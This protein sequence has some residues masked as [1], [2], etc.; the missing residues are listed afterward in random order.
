MSAYRTNMVPYST[1]SELANVYRAAVDGMRASLLECGK[2]LDALIEGFKQ[3]GRHS[4]YFGFG[5]SHMQSKYSLDEK[6][7][8]LL[9]REMKRH[10]WAV[11]VE[12]IEI[13]KVMSAK[14]QEE[15]RQA[16]YYSS[17]R[18]Y[19]RNE[20][21][22]I[23]AFPEITPESIIDVLMGMVSSAPE[24]LEE[25]IRE[26]FEWL[27]CNPGW[28]KL[29]TNE[30]NEF[31]VDRKVI[32]YGCVEKCCWDGQYWRTSYGREANLVALDYIFHGLDG[33]GVPEGHSGPLVTAIKTC[34]RD[35]YGTTEYFKFRCCKNSNLHIEFRR[36]DLLKEFNRIA[37]GGTLGRD[38]SA[39]TEPPE[40]ADFGTGLAALLEESA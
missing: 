32:K 22:P 19:G 28:D 25:K 12:K 1:A 18:Q 23:D 2:H 26:Q 39:P 16:F 37:G 34:G 27:K 8:D 35:G 11:L 17:G 40:Q 21:D 29:K 14:Q 30:K 31:R 38:R 4:G 5:I 20:P 9:M 6:G 15:M 7:V 3:E 24:F 33:K 10:A 36:E 13:S